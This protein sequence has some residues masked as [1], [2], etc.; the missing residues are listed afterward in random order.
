VQQVKV[1]GGIDEKNN[2]V[3]GGGATVELPELHYGRDS[4][5]GV[6]L[7]F[8]AFG[9]KKMTVLHYVLHYPEYYMSKK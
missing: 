6:A 5:L 8:N 1:N 2:A 9:N 4:L 7:F 3:I